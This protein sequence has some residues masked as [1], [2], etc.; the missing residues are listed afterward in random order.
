MIKI[1]EAEIPYEAFKSL[2][3]KRSLS[4]KKEKSKRKKKHNIRKGK[5]SIQKSKGKK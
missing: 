1:N 3:A 5:F 2:T 4:S